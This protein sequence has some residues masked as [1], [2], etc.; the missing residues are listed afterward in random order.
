MDL[1]FKSGLA[2]LNCVLSKS[3]SLDKKPY[4]ITIS[5]TFLIMGSSSLGGGKEYIRP[6]GWNRFALKVKGK[7]PD[8]IWLEGKTPQADQYSSAEGEWPVSYHG[9]SLNNGLSIAEEGKR[10][11]YGEGIYST[12]DIEVA[13]KYTVSIPMNGKT[14]KVIMQNRV[15]PR[16]VK[17]VSKAETGVGEYWISPSDDDVRPYGIYNSALKNV[18]FSLHIFKY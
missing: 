16:N 2:F 13:C 5:S 15:N 18:D 9:T 14:C 4:T 1:K 10:L 17:I 3:S 11:N 8:D 7:Y 6:C 12:P